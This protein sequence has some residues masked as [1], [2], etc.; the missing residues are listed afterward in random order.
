MTGSDSWNFKEIDFNY[1]F[2]M[3]NVAPSG[4]ILFILIAIT[5]SELVIFALFNRLL[6]EANVTIFI[7]SRS[8]KVI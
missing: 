5:L 2:C 6:N 3:S 1:D 4:V 8:N 7:K